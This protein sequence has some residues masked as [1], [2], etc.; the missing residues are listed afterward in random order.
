MNCVSKKPKIV[1]VIKDFA[2]SEPEAFAI[3]SSRYHPLSYAHLVFQIDHVD[4][5]LRKS[6]FGTSS[7]I[8]ITVRD[9][10]YAVLAIVTLAC[11]AVAVPLDPNM[12]TAEVETRFHSLKIDAVCVLVG[13]ET[14]TRS[15]AE[16]QGLV[17]IELIPHNGNDPLFSMSVSA[18]SPDTPCD[19]DIAIIFQTSGTTAKPRFVPCRHSNLL[20]AARRTRLWFNLNEKDR[21]L[22]VAS[23]YYS[24]GLTFSILASLLSGGSIAVPTNITSINLDEW[25]DVLNPTWYSASP[26]MHLA[27]SEKWAFQATAVK[28]RLRFASSGGARL[29]ERVQSAFEENLGF[30]ILEHYG[31]TE[32][33]QISSN[34]TQPGHYKSGTVGIPPSGTMAVV[35]N[36][37]QAMPREQEGEVWIRGPNVMTGYLNE[38][39]LN[40]AVFV[41]G[42]F[43]TGDTGLIDR[44]GFLILKDRTKEVIN[45]GGEKLS[46]FEIENVLLQHPDVMEVAAFA[47]PHPRLGEDG[48]VALV[49]RPGAVVAPEDL[50]RFMSAKLSWNKIPRRYHVVESLPKGPGGKVLRRRLRERFIPDE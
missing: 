10:V 18:S 24:H 44:E 22:S 2:R 27:I 3:V 39:E 14:A 1:D 29:S 30:K 5:A 50:R 45:R 49:L 23:P 40:E 41:N 43:R 4:D 47:V 31:M 37:G 25:F 19:D 21:C 36:E 32:A 16:K 20:A 17:V 35:G 11:S 38:P 8:A 7:R 12:V 42:W 34:L 9:P 26:T 15:V 13:E 6:G 48:A 33:C 46:P 28:H